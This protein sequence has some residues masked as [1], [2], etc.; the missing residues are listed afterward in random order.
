MLCNLSRSKLHDAA[1]QYIRLGY[2]IGVSKK[3]ELINEY[4]TQDGDWDSITFMLEGMVCVDLDC[5]T[6]LGKKYPLPETLK[7]RSPRGL[8]FFYKLPRYFRGSTKV[9][10]RKKVDLLTKDNETLLYGRKP[11]Q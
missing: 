3:K 2:R 6:D 5:F 9:G 1:A 8:H 10:W 4:Y 11:K 7:E